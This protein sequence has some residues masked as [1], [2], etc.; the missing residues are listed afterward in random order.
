MLLGGEA[1]LGR[2]TPW[3]DGACRSVVVAR[4][5]PTV[6]LKFVIATSG[7]I[8]DTGVRNTGARRELLGIGKQ[9]ATRSE[10]LKPV[11][12]RVTVFDPS[13]PAHNVGVLTSSAVLRPLQP[14]RGSN[15]PPEIS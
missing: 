14:G 15:K 2:A 4:S 13:D 11:R 8:H 3:A 7:N 6:R 1:E 12:S 10:I 9:S 5:P